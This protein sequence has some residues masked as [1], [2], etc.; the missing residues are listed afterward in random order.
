MDPSGEKNAQRGA[1]LD[2]RME[3]EEEEEEEWGCNGSVTRME[4]LKGR[5]M[6][7]YCRDEDGDGEDG[8]EVV[9]AK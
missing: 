5:A 2:G 9:M 6:G 7:R 4:V 8:E 3:E 1:G